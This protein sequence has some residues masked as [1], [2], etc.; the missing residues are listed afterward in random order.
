MDSVDHDQMRKSREMAREVVAG[1]I[2][3]RRTRAHEVGR[4]ETSSPN[5]DAKFAVVMDVRG[6]ASGTP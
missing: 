6:H 2:D 3:D 5:R 1:L 4:S